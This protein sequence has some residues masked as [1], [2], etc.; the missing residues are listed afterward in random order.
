[1]EVIL[2]WKKQKYFL[3]C[4]HFQISS[5]RNGALVWCIFGMYYCC[6]SSKYQLLTFHICMY[7]I[8]LLL[9]HLSAVLLKAK[10]QQRSDYFRILFFLM[11]NNLPTFTNKALERLLGCRLILT[12]HLILDQSL[13]DWLINVAL[14]NENVVLFSSATFSRK[15][16]EPLSKIKLINND[17]W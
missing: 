5:P 15:I 9:V 6:K 11:Q 4:Q 14:G 3:V 16:T 17:F 8:S 1:M 12:L 10:S 13:K 7:H 2:S